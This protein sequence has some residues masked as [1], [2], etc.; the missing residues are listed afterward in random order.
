MTEPKPLISYQI[1]FLLQ[2]TCTLQIGKLGRF[3]FPAGHYTYTGSAKRNI[4]ARIERHLKKNKPLRWHIDHLLAVPQAQIINTRKST[5]A[6]CALN[7]NT[8]G[9]IIAPRFGATDC[10]QGCGSHLKYKRNPS[11]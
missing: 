10:R 2:R 8:P 4:D 9:D 3:T 1:F 5:Q 11:M 6:E 7:R